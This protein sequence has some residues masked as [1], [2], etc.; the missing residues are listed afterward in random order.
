MT[1]QGNDEDLRIAL[2]AWA[3]MNRLSDEAQELRDRV[4]DSA[5]RSEAWRE[6]MARL[7]IGGD[8]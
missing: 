7:L 6:R 3:T 5:A 2:R 1:T 8:E 4:R